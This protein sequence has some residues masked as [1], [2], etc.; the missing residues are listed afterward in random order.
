MYDKLKFYEPCP[1]AHMEHENRMNTICEQLRQI[2][3]LTENPEIK[4]RARIATT[5]AKKMSAKLAEY[6]WDWQERFLE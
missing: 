2:Y 6:K 1:E 3:K 5:M 4:L